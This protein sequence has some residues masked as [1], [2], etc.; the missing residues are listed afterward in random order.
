MSDQPPQGR[1]G[2]VYVS[3]ALIGTIVGLA[4]SVGAMVFYAGGYQAKIDSQEKHFE[5]DDSRLD[6]L[7]DKIVDIDRRLSIM[8]SRIR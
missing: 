6:R 7:S 1:R 8:Q 4:M 3:A 5:F 2:G